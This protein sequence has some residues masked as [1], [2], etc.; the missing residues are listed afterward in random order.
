M[1]TSPTVAEWASLSSVHDL[2]KFIL[3]TSLPKTKGHNIST[4]QVFQCKGIHIR[5][6]MVHLVNLLCHVADLG[7]HVMLAAPST[8][9]LI[10]P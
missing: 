6:L 7:I 3:M 2:L 4:F 8:H 10:I 5:P 9:M 1:S